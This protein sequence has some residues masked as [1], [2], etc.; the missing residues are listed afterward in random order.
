VAGDFYDFFLIDKDTLVILI[1]DV[2]GKGVP[3]ALFMV[4]AKTLIK[5]NALY[6]MSPKEVFET[7]NNLL[8]VNNEEGMFV[9]VFM[10]YLDIPTG[11]FTC[12]NAGHNPPLIKQGDDFGWLKIKPGL[13]LGGMEDMR[14]NQEELTLRSGDEVYLYTDG[15][16]EAMNPRRELFTDPRLLN[17][18]NVYKDLDLKG[19]AV[20][21]KSEIDKFAEGAKQADDITMLVLKYR[22]EQ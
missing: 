8:C 1:A 10:A 3:A 5:N 6:N 22:G 17:A 2:S 11:K 14:Y 12:V 19:F 20:S 16:T 4:I 9:T 13:V 15:V 18:A 21:I 7:V